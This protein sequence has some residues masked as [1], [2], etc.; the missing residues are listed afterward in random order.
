MVIIPR[1]Q[2]VF[3][4]IRAFWGPNACLADWEEVELDAWLPRAGDVYDRANEFCRHVWLNDGPL[5]DAGIADQFGIV[6]LFAARH[7]EG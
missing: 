4:A 7:Q 3:T 6:V 2:G 5:G 1:D